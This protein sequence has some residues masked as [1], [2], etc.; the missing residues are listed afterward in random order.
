MNH[1]IQSIMVATMLFGIVLTVTATPVAALNTDA[2]ST[3]PNYASID[4]DISGTWDL[5]VHPY[6]YADYIISNTDL[7]NCR[8]RGS[9]ADEVRA[10]AIAYPA[11]LTDSIAGIACEDNTPWYAQWD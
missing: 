10:H 3:S 5:L 11:G 8:T 1:K 7:G 4:M 6:D 9:L 2:I